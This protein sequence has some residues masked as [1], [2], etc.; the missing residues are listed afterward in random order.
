MISLIPGLFN[1][2]A[3]LPE[4]TLEARRKNILLYWFLVLTGIS[5]FFARSIQDFHLL[6]PVI[7][8]SVFIPVYL[9]QHRKTRVVQFLFLLFSLAIVLNNLIFG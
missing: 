3:H 1:N 4:K 9:L 5:F 2:I 8:L 6:F 7:L